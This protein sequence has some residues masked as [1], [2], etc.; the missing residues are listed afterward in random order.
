MLQALLSYGGLINKEAKK[1][2]LFE[3]YDKANL[4]DEAIAKVQTEFEKRLEENA[5]LPDGIRGKEA[6]IYPESA[7]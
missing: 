7:N 6:F 5:D 3:E 1:A 4:S 2:L